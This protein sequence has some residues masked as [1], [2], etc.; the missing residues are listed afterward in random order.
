MEHNEVINFIK[1]IAREAR[2]L[3]RACRVP[4]RCMRYIGNALVAWGTS[5]TQ[6]LHAI[7]PSMSTPHPVS[8]AHGCL[9][10]LAR[11]P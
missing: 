9:F 7:A 10:Q 1:E 11:Y 3:G 6:L 4:R 5:P 2:L 8:A